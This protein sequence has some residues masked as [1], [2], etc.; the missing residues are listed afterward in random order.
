MQEIE[1][2]I[3]NGYAR[4]LQSISRVELLLAFPWIGAHL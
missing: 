3:R 1:L 4:R 2:T